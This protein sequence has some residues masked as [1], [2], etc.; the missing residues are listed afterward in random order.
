MVIVLGKTV[1]IV[2]A[3]ASRDGGIPLTREILQ[4]GYQLVNDLSER[5][6]QKYE[7][8]R[9]RKEKGEPEFKL[10]SADK[11]DFLDYL[12]FNHLYTFKKVYSFL[13]NTLHWNKDPS[14]LPNI[15]ELW[16]ILEIATE[17]HANFEYAANETTMTSREIKKALTSLINYV[18]WGCK[19]SDEPKW[20]VTYTYPKSNSYEGF[21]KRLPK[22]RTIISLNYDTWLDKAIRTAN[23]PVDYG[24]DFIPYEPEDIKLREEKKSETVL[25]LKPHGSFNWLY[26]PTCN[27]IEDFGHIHVSHIPI[28]QTPYREIDADLLCK[29]DRTMREAVMVP[30]SLVKRYG[31][32][33]HLDIIWRRMAEELKTAEKVVFIGYSF[34][35]ADIHIKYILFQSILINKHN[36]WGNEFSITVVNRSDEAIKEYER[37]FGK[38]KIYP[39]KKT[40]SEYV[41]QY[42]PLDGKQS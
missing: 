19:V 23:L 2:G 10:V 35:G 3:G 21:V 25:L 22:E 16:G 18:L 27:L 41:E 8:A 28:E 7:E 39:L 24:S 30:P 40:F 20:H 11:L 6:N 4:V 12:N 13:D 36:F 38:G 42:M 37:W 26:C 34:R 1:Y 17:R 31:I 5:L 15:K 33:P 32:N 14:H 9:R 29:Y